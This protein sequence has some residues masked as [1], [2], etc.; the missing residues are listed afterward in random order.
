M[1]DDFKFVDQ[2]QLVEVCRVDSTYFEHAGG[3]D[4]NAVSFGVTA[5][6]VDIGNEVGPVKRHV[7]RHDYRIRSII[8]IHPLA[9][10]I[11]RT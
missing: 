7:V 11:D 3:A 5:A 6:M 4:A 1:R 9:F 2:A 10:L 8:R